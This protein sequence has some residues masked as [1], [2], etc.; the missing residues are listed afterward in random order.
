MAYATVNPNTKDRR[1]DF[2]EL[3]APAD[4]VSGNLLIVGPW[5]CVATSKAASGAKFTANIRE[6]EEIDAVSTVAVAA[7]IG[8]AIYYNPST[9]A[10][11]ASSATGNAL[12]GYTTVVKD[13]NNNFRFAKVKFATV[14]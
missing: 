3:T 11:A 14:A 10:F 8:A 12:V 7:S 9:G 13:A 6:G 1:T 4:V 2:I 5:L